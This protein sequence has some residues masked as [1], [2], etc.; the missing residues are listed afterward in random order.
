MSLSIVFGYIAFWSVLFHGLALWIRQ[1]KFK[2]AAVIPTLLVGLVVVFSVSGMVFANSYYN[3]NNGANPWNPLPNDPIG[4]PRGVN[5]GRVTWVWDPDATE[6][7]LQGFWWQQENND[8]AVIDA[9]VSTG[10]RGL[11][12]VDDD[13]DAWELLFTYFNQVHGNGE[14]GYQPGEKIAIKINLNNCWDY[15]GD[16]YTTKDYERDASPYAVKALLRQLVTVV[17]VAQEDITVYDAS[18]MMGNWF[19]RRVYYETYPAT[20]LVPEFPDVNFVDADGGASGRQKVEASAH[21]IYFADGTGLYRTLPTCVTD[22]KYLINMPILKRHPIL[23]GVTL[24]GKNFFGTW[25][26]PV[27]DVHEYHE[28]AF[29]LGNPTPQTDLLAH[30]QI[31][32]NTL[33]YLGDGMF[34]T[35]VDHRTIAKFQMYPFNNDWTNSLFFSQDPVA[36]DSVMYDFLHA[37]G[38]NPNE[39]SQNYLHQSAEPPADVYDPEGDGEYLNESLGVHEHWDTTVDIFSSERYVGPT[40]NGIDFVTYGKEH[41]HPAIIIT[42]PQERFL[43]MFGQVKDIRL[44]LAVVIGSIDVEAQINGATEVVDKV[45]FYLDDELVSTVYEEPYVWTW[46]KRSFFRH[47]ITAVAFY[48]DASTM[49]DTVIVWKFL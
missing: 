22:A 19:Y 5:P 9:M 21:R 31:G 3:Q 18:R 28:D 46:D 7:D 4:T 39:G 15:I 26:E 42:Q 49:T 40:G 43:Y 41:A 17:G 1:V 2:T 36:L 25:I 12:G 38:T 29:T 33:L 13:S 47:A 30:K 48:G 11:A 8:Q 45:E 14:V 35:C 32:G 23:N 27:A 10:V 20:P 44:P 6:S 34:G 24:S 37:E 16:P